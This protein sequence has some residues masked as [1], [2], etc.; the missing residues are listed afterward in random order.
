[1]YT[2]YAKYCKLKE[3]G[4]RKE[5]NRAAEQVVV[6]YSN[7]PNPDFV[8][9]ICE[10]VEDRLN[11]HLWSGIVLP[12]VKAD[13]EGNPIAIKCLIQ[14][15]QNLY[16]DGSAHRELEWISEEQ[17]IRRYLALCPDDN[18]ATGRHKELLA[19]WLA[20]TIHEW[21]A[22]VLY[23]N[24]GAT[25]EQCGEIL[26]AITE[27]AAIDRDSSYRSLCDDVKEKTVEYRDRLA[28]QA[29]RRAGEDRDPEL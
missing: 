23:G 1:M 10:G 14:T 21:P 13:L 19:R 24:D 15:I 25:V 28:N 11:Y 5:A 16:S 12:F 2:S 6:D 22:G 26:E 9:S 8:V 4:F 18:W 29:F 20:H 17:L 27:L 3:S 7:D